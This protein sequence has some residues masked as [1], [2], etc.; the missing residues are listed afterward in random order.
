M[1]SGTWIKKG[2]R[3]CAILRGAG[4]ETAEIVTV[5]RVSKGQVWLDNGAGNDPSGPFDAKT[6]YQVEQSPFGFSRRIIQL[7]SE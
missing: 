7:V 1:A 3:V 2:M 4:T 6:G 5:L